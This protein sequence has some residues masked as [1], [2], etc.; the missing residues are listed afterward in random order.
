VSVDVEQLLDQ[1]LGDHLGLSIREVRA[2]ELPSEQQDAAR[3]YFDI[4]FTSILDNLAERLPPV[5]WLFQ[6]TLGYVL[7]MNSLPA[8]E[9]RQRLL[10][11][12]NLLLD[13]GGLRPVP[14]S[15]SASRRVWQGGVPADIYATRC[16]LSLYYL[17]A[18]PIP[19]GVEAGLVQWVG[20]QRSPTGWYY[21]LRVADTMEERKLQNE[22]T[23]QTLAALSIVQPRAP[24]PAAEAE[25]T[26]HRLLS[27]IPGLKYMGAH[28]LRGLVLLGTAVA[29]T[30]A[31]EPTFAFLQRHVSPEGGYFEYL[32][33]EAKIDEF[34]GHIQRYQSDYLTA[35]IT[36]TYWAGVIVRLLADHPDAP[37][38]VS[39]YRDSA[40]TFLSGL[41]AHASGGF[42]SRLQI[43][44]YQTPFGPV[45]SPLETL[46]VLCMPG[47]VASLR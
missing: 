46:M 45:V 4:E 19:S 44:R 12:L 15:H 24:L 7:A 35:T 32:F 5:A 11:Y 33:E 39:V 25:T 21:Q 22:L 37:E 40:Q 17:L 10:G 23:L 36:A 28:T 16:A 8:P 14:A 18:Q 27:Y 34:A 42:G 2:A 26:R 31:A 41:V 20:T 38:M 6:V 3:T 1:V 13:Q 47:L 9:Q 30:S 29:S 43:A